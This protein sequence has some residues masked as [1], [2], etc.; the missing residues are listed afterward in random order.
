M[1]NLRILTE[2]VTT[3]YSF[4]KASMRHIMTLHEDL[5]T[6]LV[7]AIKTSKIDFCVYCG[8][9][10]EKEQNRAYN[11]KKSQLQYPASLHNKVPAMA[12]DFAPYYKEN[13]HIRWEGW[14]LGNL[15]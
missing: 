9:R 7:E 12:F 8:Y 2:G 6:V 3:M 10:G 11:A 14:R 5:Q 13:P 1:T 15:S 4:G